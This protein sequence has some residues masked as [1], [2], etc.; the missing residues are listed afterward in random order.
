[1]F[2][3]FDVDDYNKYQGSYLDFDK[4][5]FGNR[6]F[7]PNELIKYIEKYIDTNFKLEEKFENM[8]E[9]YFEYTDNNNCDRVY[10]MIMKNKENLYKAK[11]DKPIKI[12]IINKINRQLNGLT[13]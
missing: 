2:Y 13:E 1:M 12:R 10:D 4:E 11:L 7:N 6:A 8:R 9:K 5:I 3:H